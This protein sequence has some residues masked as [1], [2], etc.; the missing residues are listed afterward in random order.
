METV[1]TIAQILAL[2]CLGALCIFLITVLTRLRSILVNLEKDFKE[3]AVR[4]IPVLENLEIITGKFK[5]VAATIEDEIGA[6]KLSMDSVKQI[7][8]N[9]VNFERRIQDRIERPVMETVATIAAVFKG[10]RAFFDRLKGNA[11]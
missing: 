10:V 11:S 8:E 9:V 4:A 7:A 5:N 3:F 1:L 6:I 2:V